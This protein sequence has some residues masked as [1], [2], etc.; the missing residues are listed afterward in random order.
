MTFTN[1][2]FLFLMIFFN[3][4]EAAQEQKPLV[5]LITSYNNRYFAER[6]LRSVFTQQ[7]HNYRII[8]IDDNS[9]D[10]T[11]LM[12]EKLS[13]RFEGARNFTF[14]QNKQ[15]VGALANIYYAVH[16]CKNDEI[17]V[18]LDGDDW[19]P[20]DGVLQKINEVYASPDV[21]LTHGSLKEFPPIGSPDW[22]VPVPTDIISSGKFRTSRCPSHL[23]TFYAWLFK[24]IRL[25]DLLYQG[26]FFPMSWDQAMM[27]PMVEMAG[28]RH[29]FIPDVLYIYNMANS[30]ND[31]K[32]NAQL[33]IDLE[34][35][36]R[37]MP[38]YHRL[39]SSPLDNLP[40]E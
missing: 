40:S 13:K 29:R 27:F 30:I 15:R 26:V 32:V 8:Y 20:H 11:R 39:D 24:Q 6:N 23:R 21:W 38:S 16:N 34:T 10:G 4:A 2:L 36:I 33:Q 7:Y 17:I 25:E 35:H 28:E 5:V 19:F 12:V 31:N 22:S 9:T 3:C 37:S 18:S 14:I 1:V